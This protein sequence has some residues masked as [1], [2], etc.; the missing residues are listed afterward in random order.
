MGQ[1]YYTHFGSKIQGFLVP[2][3]F[4]SPLAFMNLKNNTHQ[5]AS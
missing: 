1:N 4:L 2:G 5:G 3:V